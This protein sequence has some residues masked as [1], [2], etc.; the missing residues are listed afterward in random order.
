MIV[1]DISDTI[2]DITLEDGRKLL[3]VGTAHVSSKSVVEVEGEISRINPDCICIEL[4]EDRWK[5]VKGIKDDKLYKD[6]DLFSIIKSGKFFYLMVNI[7]LSSFQKRMSIATTGQSGREI[8]R[9][10]EIALE[11]NIE[12]LFVDRNVS[13]TLKRAWRKSSLYNKAKILS[14]L[15]AAAF[16]RSKLT[17]EEL[18]KLKQESN[19]DIM[20]S[21]IAKELPSVKEVL[22]DERDKYLANE[23]YSSRGRNIFAVVGQGHVKGL[24]K[25]LSKIENENLIIDK[26]ELES[27]PNKKKTSVF[28]YIVPT[29]IIMFLLAIGLIKGWRYGLEYFISWALCNAFSAMLGSII[30]LAHPLTWLVTLI[31]SPISA[32][33]PVLGVGMFSSLCEAS[34]RKVKVSD[35]EN[36]QEDVPVFKRWFKNRILHT[37]MIF[38]ATSITSALGTFVAF[39]FLNSLLSKILFH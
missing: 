23:I 33:S 26:A 25:N 10:G 22:I 18:E 17:E 1:I 5:R 16:D 4:D 13:I 7:I 28:S 21:E 30:S 24:L 12:L 6:F 27:V 3:I 11:R 31:T 39:P 32:L 15:F 38:I 34:V 37:F 8:I 2:K 9:A 36:V 20:L 14:S 19:I 29:I 35:F